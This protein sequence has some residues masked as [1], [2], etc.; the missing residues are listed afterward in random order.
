MTLTEANYHKIQDPDNPAALRYSNHLGD[1]QIG[2]RV[3]LHPDIDPS[4]STGMVIGVN[5]M[6]HV[7]IDDTGKRVRVYCKDTALIAKAIRSPEMTAALIE[8]MR[9]ARRRKGRQQK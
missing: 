1:F 3:V 5:G 6:V 2:D 9:P 7:L 4:R 8:A